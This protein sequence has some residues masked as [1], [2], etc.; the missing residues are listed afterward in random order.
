MDESDKPSEQAARTEEKPPSEQEADRFAAQ[1]LIPERELERFIARV[2]PLYSKQR[3]LGFAAR[4]NIHPGIVIGQLQRRGEIKYAHSRDMLLKVREY[5]I[6][7]AL[8][9]GWDHFPVVNL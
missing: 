4:L 7:S 5:V 9:E 6:G 2:R 3:I 1:F 8:T